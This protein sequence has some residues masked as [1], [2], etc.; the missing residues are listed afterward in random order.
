[1]VRSTISVVVPI[2]NEVEILPELT[3]RLGFLVNENPEYKWQIIYVDD[4]STDGSS[5]LMENLTERFPWLSV[6]FLS[7][8]FGHQ[9]ATTAGID[10]ATGDAVVLMDGDLQDPPELIPAMIFKWKQGF[11]VV[12]ATRN[13]RDGETKFKLYTAGLFYRMLQKLSNTK[14]P[15]DT[16]DFRLMSRAAVNAMHQMPE[17]NRFLRGM[18][19]WIGFKQT[20]IYYQRDKRYSGK[21][22]FTVIKMLRFATNGLLSFSTSPL[23][24]IL[25]LGILFSIIGFIGFVGVLFKTLI[26]NSASTGWIAVTMAILF[27]GGV[28]LICIGVIGEYISRI[29][30]EVRKRP[31]YL[32]RS[33]KGLGREARDTRSNEAY[34]RRTG[35][36]G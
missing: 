1:M 27:V 28:Q 4:G 10:H 33:I 30:D 15:I 11:D 9:N 16:G 25:I 26:T 17:H 19:S 14:I 24:S 13:R 36:I 5:Q 34:V 23:Y 7:R 22:K 31:L 18:S 8:N 21:T 20:A 6:V 32:V 35:T 2:Y 12:Y 3:R 29:F